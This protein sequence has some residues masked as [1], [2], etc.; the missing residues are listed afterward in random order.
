MFIYTGISLKQCW[1][2]FCF[3]AC[4]AYTKLFTAAWQACRHPGGLKER[5]ARFQLQQD[6]TSVLWK[7]VNG[8]MPKNLLRQVSC[9]HC[10]GKAIASSTALHIYLDCNWCRK[11]STAS[12]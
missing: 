8:M 2:G 6:P 11:P 12:A 4:N 3:L 9:C 5:E 7:A 1:P 10:P